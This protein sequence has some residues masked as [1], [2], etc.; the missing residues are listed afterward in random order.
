MPAVLLAL[1]LAPLQRLAL[2][3]GGRILHKTHRRQCLV[4][5]T[6]C[7]LLAAPVV[8]M[9]VLLVP[10]LQL[11]LLPG[12]RILRKTHHRQCLAQNTC[13]TARE[14]PAPAS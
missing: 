14:A 12:G 6:C 11:E 10:L 4:Q 2:L 13:C 9:V 5:N 8:R 1:L 7:T 3:P